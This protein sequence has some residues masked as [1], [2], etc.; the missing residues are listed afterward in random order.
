MK[1]KPDDS[2]LD[3]EIHGFCAT[4][5]LIVRKTYTPVFKRL[6]GTEGDEDRVAE[7]RI[8]AAGWKRM[9]AMQHWLAGGAHTEGSA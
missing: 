3:G 4:G 6:L 2:V 7:W 8:S 9:V 1:L 5:A